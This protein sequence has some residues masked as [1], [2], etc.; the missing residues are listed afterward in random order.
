M[1]IHIDNKIINPS[2]IQDELTFTNDWLEF[3]FKF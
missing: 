1:A 3:K 2:L